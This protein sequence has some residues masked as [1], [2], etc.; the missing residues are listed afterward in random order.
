MY[1]ITVG[2]LWR[3]G[4]RYL[5]NESSWQSIC[6]R[7]SGRAQR[8]SINVSRFGMEICPFAHFG[9]III[10]HTRRQRKVQLRIRR[11]ERSWWG[12]FKLKLFVPPLPWAHFYNHCDQTN[13]QDNDDR[14]DSPFYHGWH[15]W[16]RW[17]CCG[18]GCE[19]HQ[20]THCS[21]SN[22]IHVHLEHEE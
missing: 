6:L 2:G 11:D 7:L 19:F 22:S 14:A 21:A 12:H 13:H 1:V 18:R 15:Y 20:A 5:Y 8:R 16:H 17:C 10:A 4:F 3:C 9:A